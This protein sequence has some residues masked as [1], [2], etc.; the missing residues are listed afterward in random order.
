MSIN[1]NISLGSKTPSLPKPNVECETLNCIF[2]KLGQNDANI[3]WTRL[4]EVIASNDPDR[5]VVFQDI[6]RLDEISR[7]DDWQRFVKSNKFQLWFD[8]SVEQWIDFCVNTK[9]KD[10]LKN[11]NISVFDFSELHDSSGDYKKQLSN[12]IRNS[13]PELCNSCIKEE[14][15]KE[16]CQKCFELLEEAKLVKRKG[17]EI[18]LSNLLFF[19]EVD[20]VV[21]SNRWSKR[22]TKFWHYEHKWLILS[23]FLLV[24]SLFAAFIMN[25]FG[26]IISVVFMLLS[27]Y[28]FIKYTLTSKSPTRR[29]IQLHLFLL[30]IYFVA[31]APRYWFMKYSTETSVQGHIIT[32]RTYQSHWISQGDI[33]PIEIQVE[34]E[35][36]TLELLR[37]SLS[38]DNDIIDFYYQEEGSGCTAAS[39]GKD[40]ISLS[41]Y[42]GAP[43]ES[44]TLCF[45]LGSNR[46]QTK[47][48]NMRLPV[49]PPEKM[50]GT[51]VIRLKPQLEATQLATAEVKLDVF[52]ISSFLWTRQ[53]FEILFPWLL[54]IIPVTH[55]R[56][57]LLPFL[58]V[59]GPII[60]EGLILEGLIVPFKNGHGGNS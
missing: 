8:V 1:V 55:M 31:F 40:S 32:I 42:R 7:D 35:E 49:L 33:I 26:V 59:I 25:T 15:H 14:F 52:P 9:K 36:N 4:G 22:F 60:L 47:I 13:L 2:Q 21:Q 18:H 24:L 20:E 58:Y 19:P 34:S 12:A 45:W 23:F 17:G 53:H 5:K 50:I 30:T 27:S 37:V 48:V 39:H 29:V 56:E 46:I 10:R 43:N 57:T 28:Y 6:G 11:I 54:K 16:N 44:I 41:Q 38:S 3:S 51:V